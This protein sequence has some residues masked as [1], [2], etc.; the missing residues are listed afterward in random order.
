MRPAIASAPE[1]IAEAAD[2]GAV[3]RD[4][5]ADELARY[6]LHA[7]AAAAGSSSSAAVQRLVGVTM[8]GLRP[9]G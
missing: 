2:A 8:A 6:C 3:R 1:L 5:G 7:L 9:A 4:V